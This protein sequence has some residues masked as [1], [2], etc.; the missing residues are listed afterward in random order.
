MVGKWTCARA[1]VEAAVA[2][3]AV[4]SIMIGFRSIIEY[5]D[6]LRVFRSNIGD[7]DHIWE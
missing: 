1:W 3:E 5:F 4:R 6:Q 7:F 2:A